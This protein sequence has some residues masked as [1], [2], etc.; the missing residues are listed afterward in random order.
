MMLSAQRMIAGSIRGASG[1]DDWLSH[2]Q[3]GFDL[4]V[5]SRPLG[6]VG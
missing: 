2:W 1:G 4:F 6:S 3:R 5:I